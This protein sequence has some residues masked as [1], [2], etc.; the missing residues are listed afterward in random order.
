MPWSPFLTHG[1][2]SLS[3]RDF[4]AVLLSSCEDDTFQ[5]QILMSRVIAYAWE[6]QTI[7]LVLSFLSYVIFHI[8]Y[9]F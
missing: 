7:G 1:A 4:P 2:P 9:Y 6:I 5:G 3:F 8:N